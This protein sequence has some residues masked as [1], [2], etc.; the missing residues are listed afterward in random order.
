MTE[1]QRNLRLY[2]PIYIIFFVLYLSSSLADSTFFTWRNN[3]NLFTRATPLVLVGIGQ[4]L[5]ILTGGIDLSIGATIGLANVIA[6]SLPF[7]GSASNVLL[8]LFVPALVGLGVGLIN[9]VI[10][11]RGGF[12]PL[13]VTLATGSVWGGVALFIL[14]EPGGN[15]SSAL[16]SFVTGQLFGIIPF[17]LVILI[18]S[19]V[20]F[21]MVLTRTAFGR[22]IYAVGGNEKVAEESGILCSRM[23]VWVYGLSGLLGGFVGIFLSARMST[24]D[25]LVGS[26]FVLSS[27][28]VAVIGGTSLMGGRGGIIGIIGA[29]YIFEMLNN[30]LNLLAISTFYQF[31]ATGLVIIIALAITSRGGELKLGSLARFLRAKSTRQA[32]D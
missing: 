28:A 7:V 10:I 26:P 6:A 24:G 22:S 1:R 13:I 2:L 29:A 14:G 11:T 3:V 17:P 19:V 32:H 21:Q 12:P 4:T 15:V 8:W 27:I 30:I 16:A 25:P 31:V 20:V 5:V 9:G 23:K 18:L